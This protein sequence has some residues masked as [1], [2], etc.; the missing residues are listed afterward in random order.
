MMI[1]RYI[2]VHNPGAYPQVW[3]YTAAGKLS[4]TVTLWGH[5]DPPHW[6]NSVAR[7]VRDAYR[8][9]TGDARRP[10]WIATTAL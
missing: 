2:L 3:I 6:C 5:S 4:C 9:T 8:A 1:R 10:R 7:K